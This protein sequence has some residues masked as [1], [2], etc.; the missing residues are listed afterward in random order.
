MA[1]NLYSQSFKNISSAKDLKKFET[2][3]KKST[4]VLRSEIKASKLA[5]IDVIFDKNDL[6]QFTKF[7]IE[8]DQHNVVRCKLLLNSY[9]SIEKK[10]KS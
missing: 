3:C 6:K 5:S 8:I 9:V 2:A 1:H 10:L 4:E 7:N